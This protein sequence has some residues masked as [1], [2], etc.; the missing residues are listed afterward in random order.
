[1]EKNDYKVNKNG[2]NISTTM[3]S[4]TEEKKWSLENVYGSDLALEN[5]ISTLN[6][7]D[8]LKK[9]YPNDDV[10]QDFEEIIRDEIC[11][12]FGGTILDFDE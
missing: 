2:F 12:M 8:V 6:V 10:V 9:K 11:Q 3:D 4:Y 7:T 5:L 1:M